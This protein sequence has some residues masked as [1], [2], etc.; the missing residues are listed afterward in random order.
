MTISHLST[1]TDQW[2]KEDLITKERVGR[3]VDMEITEKGE[4]LCKLMKKF[5]DLATRQEIKKGEED[6]KDTK[7][8]D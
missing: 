3:E 1:V 4:E 8:E 6:G 5:D 7:G 2:E